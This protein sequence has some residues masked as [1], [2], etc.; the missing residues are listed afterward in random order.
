M[1]V[2]K[3]I[4]NYFYQLKEFYLRKAQQ[5]GEEVQHSLDLCG[6]RI[7]INLSSQALAKAITP[8]LCLPQQ[9]RKSQVDFNLFVFNSRSQNWPVA[10][11]ESVLRLAKKEAL[12]ERPR[13]PF[14]AYLF[15]GNYFCILWNNCRPLAEMM[16]V[17]FEKKEAVVC[18]HYAGEDLG[19][20]CLTPLRNILSF[21]LESSEW[22]L[23]HA[24]AVGTETG[25]VLIAGGSGRGKSTVAASCLGSNLLYAGDDA[26]FVSAAGKGAVLHSLYST[27][28]V[29]KKE[30]S[31]YPSLAPLNFSLRNDSEKILFSLSQKPE[32]CIAQFP[33]AAILIPE[34]GT[35]EESLLYPISAGMALRRIA[36]SSLTRLVGVT[37]TNFQ[38]LSDLVQKVPCYRLQ[39]GTYH[40]DLPALI[41]NLLQSLT[42]SSG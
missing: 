33:L 5:A 3:D 8:L 10:I 15:R 29:W 22:L 37:T 27:C 1:I 23:L 7:V 6:K 21:L 34:F 17:N 24:S 4:G 18:Y 13:T 20:V 39:L 38:R 42:V 26:V 16:V 32:L 41:S 12:K 14:A 31:R 40:R 19:S 25:G 2:E 28:S 11:P 30:V 36:P 9:I 35:S